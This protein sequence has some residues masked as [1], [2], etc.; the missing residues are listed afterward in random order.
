M[1]LLGVFTCEEKK[2]NILKVLLIL[3]V[4]FILGLIINNRIY[5]LIYSKVN[6]K[7]AVLTKS[8]INDAYNI[9]N[10]LSKNGDKIYKGFDGESTDLILYNE[11]YEFLLS[12]GKLKNNNNE[13][14]YMEYNKKLSK[15]I[16]RRK[17]NNP[18]AFAV[19]VEDRWVGS[20]DTHD[21]YN[22]SVLEQVPIFMP[23]QGLKADKE[24]YNAIVIHEMAHAYQG[25][26]NYKR[27]DEDEHYDNV[28]SSYFGKNDF[29]DLIYK[30]TVYLEKTAKV[31]DDSKRKEYISK[32][33]ELRKERRENSNMSSSD[34]KKEQELEWL[35]GTG[36]YAEYYASRNS[37]S[38]IAKDLGNV[39]KE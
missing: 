12:K 39:S 17:A 10:Y 11:K 9:Y 8:E 34:I 29:E 32:F 21:Y 28:C 1:V 3:V 20:F 22:K 19:K 27:V 2:K 4:V 31:K 26:L 24:Y 5:Y 36:R 7:S 35:E 30:E 33:L 14:K 13:W 25:N 37:K 38:T 16:Y 18:Q 23:P 15:Y 6:T